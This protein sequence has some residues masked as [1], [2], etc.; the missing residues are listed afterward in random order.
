MND[1]ERE[2][3]KAKTDALLEQLILSFS[4][5]NIVKIEK[6]IL[7][8]TFETIFNDAYETGRRDGIGFALSK[9]E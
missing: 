9:K 8:K 4:Q 2:I 5:N 7:L 1:M 3:T 6:E